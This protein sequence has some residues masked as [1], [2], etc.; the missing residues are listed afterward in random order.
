M[1][2]WR[3][4]LGSCASGTVCT[5]QGEESAVLDGNVSVAGGSYGSGMR[6]RNQ[7]KG[8]H[9]PGR[10]VF[11]LRRGVKQVYCCRRLSG[12]ASTRR[13]GKESR[14]RGLHQ[15]RSSDISETN[16]THER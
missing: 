9:T 1:T 6:Q 5:G 13:Q 3:G 8:A 10:G 15:G 14:S 11:V 12:H 16:L 7:G 4:H 2:K